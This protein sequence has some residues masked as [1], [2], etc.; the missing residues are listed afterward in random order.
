MKPFD[1]K[2]ASRGEP[3]CLRN[4]G[5]VKI[6]STNLKG[7]RPV[8]GAIILDGQEMFLSW[9]RSGAYKA[10]LATEFDLMMDF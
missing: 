2:A 5:E 7:G 3:V 8:S 9:T 4:G 6:F 1:L 10:D